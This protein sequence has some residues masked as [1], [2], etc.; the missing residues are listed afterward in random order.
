[1]ECEKL[2]QVQQFKRMKYQYWEK[3]ST[4]D[5][6]RQGMKQRGNAGE[7]KCYRKEEG[8]RKE[9]KMTIVWTIIRKGKGIQKKNGSSRI[10]KKH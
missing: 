2:R 1:M 4:G 9:M 5:R 3:K 10:T 8:G 7:E 6:G